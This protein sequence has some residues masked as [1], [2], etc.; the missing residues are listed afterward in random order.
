MD[1]ILKGNYPIP[2]LNEKVKKVEENKETLQEEFE[3]AALKKLGGSITFIKKSG[4]KGS[5]IWKGDKKDE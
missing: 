2:D 5:F 4:P 1:K 3:A